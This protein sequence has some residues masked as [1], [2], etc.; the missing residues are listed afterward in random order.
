MIFLD[1]ESYSDGRNVALTIKATSSGA[2]ID[3]ELRL[4]VELEDAE[5]FH[6]ELGQAIERSKKNKRLTL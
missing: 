2:G 6:A 5:Q 1:A 4:D 3:T